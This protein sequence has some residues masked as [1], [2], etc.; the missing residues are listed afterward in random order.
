MMI[1]KVLCDAQFDRNS[2][3]KDYIKDLNH[4]DL[5]ERPL[6]FDRQE[7]QYWITEDA[8]VFWISRCN[9]KTGENWELVRR[10]CLPNQSYGGRRT[11]IH[12][13]HRFVKHLRN[14]MN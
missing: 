7:R 5:R 2:A 4:K 9:A 3:F 6:G 10:S 12:M 8:T 13:T 11:H 1:L 14:S